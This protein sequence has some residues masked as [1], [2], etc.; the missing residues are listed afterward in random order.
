MT[1]A[2]AVN[3]ERGTTS[4]EFALTL[5]LF[6]LI[7]AGVLGTGLLFWAQLG[8]QHGVEMAARCASVDRDV[9]GATGDIQNYAA[10]QSSGLNPPPSVFSVSSPPCGVQVTASY[11]VAAISSIWNVPPLTLTARSCY[12]K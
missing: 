8:L 4:I 10:A 11:S 1:P 12:P 5:P 7:L 9:C 6:L 2:D 3:D